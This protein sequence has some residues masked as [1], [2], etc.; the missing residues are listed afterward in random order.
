[1]IRLITGVHE[2]ESCRYI[3]RKF[4]ILTLASLY[5]L[6]VLYFIKKYQGNLKQ[7]LGI[8]GHNTRN[9]FYMHTHYCSTIIYQRSATNL[10]IKLLNKLPIQIKQLNNYK[11]FRREVKTFV[12]HNSFYTIEEFLHFEGI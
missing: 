5:I 10:G 6:E 8:H 7:N 2:R 4:Q 11:G 1:M 3:F 12:L 9:K